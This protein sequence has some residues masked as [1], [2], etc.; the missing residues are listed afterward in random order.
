MKTSKENICINQIIGQ[1]F[2]NIII[3]GDCIIPDIKPD[4]LS[5]INTNGNVCIYKKEIIDGKIKLDGA[6]NVYIMYLPDSERSNVR[7]VNTTIDFSYMVNME[8]IKSGMNL[9]TKINL[10]AIDCK[11]LN[12]RKVSIKALLDGEFKVSSNEKVEFINEVDNVKNL[13]ILNETIEVNSLLGEGNTKVYAKET[14]TIDNADNLVDIMKC[15]IRILNKETKTSYNKVLAKADTAVSVMYLTEDNRLNEVKT[16]IPI[17]GFI[18]IQNV[19]DDNICDVNYE[20]KNIIIKPNGVDEHSIYLEIEIEINCLVYENKKIDLIEDL[21]SPCEEITTTSK[22]IQVMQNKQSF[23]NVCNI[24][25]KQ[26]IEELQGRQLYNVEVTPTIVRENKLNDKIMY[27]GEIELKLMYGANNSS[28]LD[29][30][31]QK[32]PFNHTID[33]NNIPTNAVTNTNMEIVSQD[34]LVMPDNTIEMKIDLLFNVDTA[35]PSNINVVE[36]INVSE[37]EK[38]EP[39]SIVIYYVKNGDSLWKI[40]KRFKSTVKDI[41]AVNDITDVDKIMVGQQLYIPI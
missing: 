7:S 11:V 10:K 33:V 41:A 28:G 15:N 5:V 31:I 38:E 12:G 14:I 29:I 27:E 36:D 2:E 23:Q 21:Y 35:R 24:R 13:Q 19:N 26:T 30:K 37:M 9:E 34:F 18:D 22:S 32:M 25:E 17:M 6:I 20:I 16:I 3:E 1:K 4:I 39:Y 8:K 40:A